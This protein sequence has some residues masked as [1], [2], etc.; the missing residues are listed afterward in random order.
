MYNHL[1]NPEKT[2]TYQQWK[3]AR[4]KGIKPFCLLQMYYFP[5]FIYF[6]IQSTSPLKRFN[7]FHFDCPHP[8][9]A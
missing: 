3:G 9:G 8:F 7:T 6:F 5:W 2:C 4:Y 1:E